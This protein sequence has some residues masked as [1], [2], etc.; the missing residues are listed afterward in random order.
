VALH[1]AIIGKLV[2]ST[3]VEGK[4]RVSGQWANHVAFHCAGCDHSWWMDD[5]RRTHISSCRLQSWDL[6]RSHCIVPLLHRPNASTIAQSLSW[7][8]RRNGK[9]SYIRESPTTPMPRRLYGYLMS[10]LACRLRD[11]IHAI[12]YMQGTQGDSRRRARRR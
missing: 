8:S 10:L 1:R 6:S 12:E 5:V 4:M 11:L 2:V 3:T 7:R 9:T